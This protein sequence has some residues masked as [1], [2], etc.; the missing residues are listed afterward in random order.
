MFA[1]AGT[2][3]SRAVCPQAVTAE[4]ASNEHYAMQACVCIKFSRSPVRMQTCKHK[5]F[6]VGNGLYVCLHF[7]HASGPKTL[8]R[9]RAKPL[10]SRLGGPSTECCWEGHPLVGRAAGAR[11]VPTRSARHTCFVGATYL[12][13]RAV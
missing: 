7:A 5:R 4:Q 12:E 11:W 2:R 1:E 10:A 13:T 8:G 9:G 6:N 3:A